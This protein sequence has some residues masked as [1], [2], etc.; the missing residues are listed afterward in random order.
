[1]SSVNL[2]KYP[3][4]TQIWDLCSKYN[5][6]ETYRKYLERIVNAAK[7]VS[8][9][10]SKTLPI[11]MATK[12]LANVTSYIDI[13]STDVVDANK[14][15]ASISKN[16]KQLGLESVNQQDVDMVNTLYT[17]FTSRKNPMADKYYQVTDML[18]AS[19]MEVR[20]NG[21][22]KEE[23]ANTRTKTANKLLRMLMDA[24]E[25]TGTRRSIGC[26]ALVLA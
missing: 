10:Y 2:E 23:L 9:K 21:Y 7:T 4:A 13:T 6:S 8:E 25:N 5:Y 18:L 26:I 22:Q 15:C 24:P 1:M 17:I 3:D 19:L 12:G 16:H 20:K 11:C 14:V